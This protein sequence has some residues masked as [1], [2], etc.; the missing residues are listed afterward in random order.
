MTTNNRLRDLYQQQRYERLD[1]AIFDYTSDDQ[2]S[3]ED[4]IADIRTILI[5]NRAY[6]ETHI[7]RHNEA[8]AGI[9]EVEQK[10]LGGTA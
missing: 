9:H 2:T 10:Y 5:E 7:R 1:E 3:I 6:Y 8:L 4:L